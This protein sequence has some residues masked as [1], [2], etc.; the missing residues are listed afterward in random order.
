MD[1]NPFRPLLRTQADV[2]RLCRRLMTPLGFATYAVWLVF[3]DDQ[4]PRPQVIEFA[5]MPP[6]PDPAVSEQL[7]RAV[8]NLADDPHISLAFLRSRPGRG[9]PTADDRAWAEAL[10]DVGRRLG[11]PLQV[12]HLAHDADVVPLAVDDLIA[13]PA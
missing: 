11:V 7:A 10:Y 2:E 9:T 5:D 3:I 13:A 12:V 6:A 8:G 4:R 1:L